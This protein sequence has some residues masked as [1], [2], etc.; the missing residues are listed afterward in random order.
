MEIDKQLH[1]RS[2]HIY[3]GLISQW[4]SNWL[5]KNQTSLHILMAVENHEQLTGILEYKNQYR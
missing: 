3:Y 4:K 1:A 5:Q 2:I